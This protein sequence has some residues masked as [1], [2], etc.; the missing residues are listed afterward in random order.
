MNRSLRLTCKRFFW[1][2]ACR[3]HGWDYAYV[4]PWLARLPLPLGY[5]IN[6]LRGRLNAALG[7]DWRSMALGFRHVRYQTLAGLRL[8]DPKAPEVTLRTWL[9]ERYVTEAREEF[10]AALIAA[11]RVSELQCKFSPSCEKTLKE[12]HGRGL[13]LVTPHFNSIVLGMSFLARFGGKINSM[14][15]SITHDPRVHVSTQHH[16]ERRMESTHAYLNGGRLINVE[17][18]VSPLYE[19]LK[20]GETVIIV[21]DSPAPPG[22]EPLATDFLGYRLVAGGAVRMARRTGSDLCAYILHW[23]GNGSYRLELGPLVGTSA[24]KEEIDDVYRFIGNAIRRQ[25]GYWW[26]ADL[27]P[28]MPALPES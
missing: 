20:H 18:G 26:A 21:A 28:A 1:K 17:N 3:L 16:F 27:L 10:E 9:R 6:S 4:L 12:R 25:P 7:R 14:S 22:S 24:T 15:S 2:I 19:M 13:V 5:A 11:G 23:E 8:L